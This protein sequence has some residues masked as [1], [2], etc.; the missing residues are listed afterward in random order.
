MSEATARSI[1]KINGF[2]IA[3]PR[4]LPLFLFILLVFLLSLI[5]VWSRVQV[6]NLKYDISSLEGRLRLLGTETQQLRVEAASL[7][8]PARI[9]QVA[10]NELRLML[11][12]PEQVIT[13]E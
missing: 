13:V 8:S 1:S 12:R 9:E 7:R 5:F 11:P 4:L 6:I 3:P 10:L 2:A